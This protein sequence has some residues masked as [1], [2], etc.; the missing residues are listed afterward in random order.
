MELWDDDDDELM[1]VPKRAKR[2]RVDQEDETI[3]RTM[4]LS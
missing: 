4:E 3:H 2:C 1:L